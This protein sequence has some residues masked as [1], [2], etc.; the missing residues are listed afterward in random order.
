M[1][2]TNKA[3]RERW[4]ER[5]EAAFHRMFEGKSQEELVTLTQ[6]EEMA[7]LIAKELSAFLL[8]EHV[9]LDSAAR[10]TEA[11]SACCPKCGR[12]GERAAEEG[13]DLSERTVR[14]RAGDIPVQRERWACVDCRIFF[15]P[16]GRSPEAGDRRLQPGR[17][18]TGGTSGEQGR[19]V[20]GGE[21]R[22]AGTGGRE[23]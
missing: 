8:E 16:A 10:P 23:D 13:E 6:R 1:D 11:S 21:R 7:V 17:A 19:I 20:R 18:G 9:A 4:M 15:F 3:R 22:P 14:T 12:P 5:A 2:G